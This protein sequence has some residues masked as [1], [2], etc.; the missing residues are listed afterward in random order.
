MT[1]QLSLFDKVES[2]KIKQS[3]FKDKCDVCGKFD[4]LRG[5]NNIC[6][7]EKCRKEKQKEV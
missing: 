6:I 4:Y 3:R 2:E 7:C 1:I 5:Y